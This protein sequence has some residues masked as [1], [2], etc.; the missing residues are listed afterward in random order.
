MF[1]LLLVFVV[2]LKYKYSRSRDQLEMYCQ[3]ALLGLSSRVVWGELF[4]VPSGWELAT[5]SQRRCQCACVCPRSPSD[6]VKNWDAWVSIHQQIAEGH[7][8]HSG[9]LVEVEIHF[10]CS[11]H[12]TS[13]Q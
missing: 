12:C 8:R 10:V 4:S 5:G 13:S 1:S 3:H 11:F 9:L 7:C 2:T 6:A